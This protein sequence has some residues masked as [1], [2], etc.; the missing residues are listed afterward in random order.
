[1][2]RAE[3]G[4]PTW[5]A[6]AD[7][8]SPWPELHVTVAGIGLSGYSAA[9]ALVELGAAVTVLDDGPEADH[10]EKAAILETLGATVRLGPGASATLPEGTDLV[11]VS[12]GWRPTQPLLAQAAGLGLPLWGDV[13]LAWRLQRPDRPVPWLAVT[14]TDGKTTTVGMLESILQAAGLQAAAVG[15]VG[16]PVME[17]VLD[18]VQY[19]V[20]AVELSSFQL[21]WLD[22]ARFHSAAC[23]NVAPDH[24]EWYADAPGGDPGD[25][26]DPMAAYS[27]DK[28]RVYWQTAHSCVYNVQDKATE[29]M[30]EEADVIEGARAIGFTLEI[31]A[32]SMLGVVDDLLVD[33]AFIPQRQT[34]ALPLARVADVQPAAPHNVANALAA[35]AL[36]RSFGVPAP[37][38]AQGL[39]NFHAGHHRIETVLA[40]G[41]ITFVD[42]SKATNPHAAGAS[43][44]AFDSVVW[45]AGGQ[46]KGTT[47]DDLV[48]RFRD[49][50]KGAVVLGVDREVVADALRR[51]APEVPL[52]VLD[53][54]DTGTMQRAVAIA[55]GMARPGDT[56]LLAPGCASYDMFSGYAARGD[57]FAE[58]ARAWAATHV[59]SPAS[60]AGPAST[61]R[62]GPG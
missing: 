17:A 4:V 13:E 26:G 41:G 42:D 24:L 15:N 23:L 30:V 57:A 21:H 14:G 35:A 28:A 59:T 33:R 29:H 60:P 32:V 37:A 54:R 49:R 52:T 5:L 43:L 34:S 6:D 27:A 36:A 3:T 53:D 44:A 11:I 50:L 38:V 48:T 40:H 22:Q 46:A 10:A 2:S 7:R 61:S 55:A 31:P 58:G 25:P 45:I 19:D 47:F 9:D 39:Q 62:E 56:V 18:E 8:T 16:R 1:M 51:H 20:L 12:P